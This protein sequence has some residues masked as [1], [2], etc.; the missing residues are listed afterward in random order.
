MI[1]RLKKPMSLVAFIIIIIFV[2][3]SFQRVLRADDWKPPVPPGSCNT[4]SQGANKDVDPPYK[5]KCTPTICIPVSTSQEQD[6][7][8][9]EQ[10]QSSAST[11]TS[12]AAAV[13][14]A[15]S[16]GETNPQ[17]QF[18]G[19]IESS[20]SQQSQSVNTAR[21]NP[22]SAD[23]RMNPD[24]AA[25][26]ALYCKSGFIDVLWINSESQG[27]SAFTISLKQIESMGVPTHK[28]KIL[29]QRKMPTGWVRLYRL[30]SGQLQLVSP[31]ND[32]PYEFIFAGCDLQ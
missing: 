4:C 22:L 21:A 18:D 9:Q 19:S 23:H 30:T 20:Q 29:I 5:S 7:T 3:V 6:S 31:G 28:N 17:R 8:Q 11:E 15:Q 12:Q 27:V 26:S 2:L 13:Q 24:A 1:K 14:P 10:S 25:T 32:K 16:A